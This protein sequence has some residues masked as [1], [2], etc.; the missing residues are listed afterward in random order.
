M[1]ES[2]TSQGYARVNQRRPCRICGKPDWCSFTRD[3]QVSICMRVQQGARRVNQHGGGI[4]VHAPN[5]IPSFAHFHVKPVTSGTA[6][7][8]L[9]IR[10]LVYRTLIWLSPATHYR[11][12]L[13]DGPKGLLARGFA[14][15]HFENYG[16]LPARAEER[17]QLALLI[18]KRINKQCPEVTSLS[19]VPG[20]WQ[21]EAGWH[22]WTRT[23]YRHPLLL[24]PCRDRH[25]LI[26]ACQLRSHGSA[27]K[28][29]RYCWLSSTELPGGTSSGAPL[30]FASHLKEL[31]S[32]APVIIVEGLLKADAFT[33][34][35]SHWYAVATPGVSV[36]HQALIELCS[37]HEAVVAFD[38]D[39]LTNATVCL[40][41]A[42]LLARR[43]ES[44]GSFSTTR[45]ACWPSGAK[46]V[47]D[48][49]I[50]SLPISYISV[51][52]WFHRL[53]NDFRSRVAAL[54]QQAALRFDFKD[55]GV[56]SW[57]PG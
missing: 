8:P 23:N 13:V 18:L 45:I 24:V 6:L 21:D 14:E 47:D 16:G 7:A 29:Q 10:D 5:S 50:R 35:Q 27:H 2:R 42:A 11:Q 4:F 37:R 49:A 40:R 25:G 46:G 17:D 56:R 33:A 48:A 52:Q 19:G 32:N 34:L 9:K 57:F 39:Y 54:W 36:G 3:E 43:M 44:E 20:F 30:H 1:I 28:G 26:Q 53:G 55:S 38:Q 15:N 31:Q 51:E 41:L 12:E 22:L